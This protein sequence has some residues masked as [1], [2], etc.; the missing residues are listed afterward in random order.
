METSLA[1]RYSGS[2]CTFSPPQHLL[3][4]FFPQLEEEIRD[5]ALPVKL[6]LKIYFFLTYRNSKVRFYN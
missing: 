6:N 1:G 5:V 2:L 4:F 3:F